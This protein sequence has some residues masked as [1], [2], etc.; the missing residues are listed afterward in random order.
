MRLLLPILL[1]LSVFG[2]PHTVLANES[3]HEA[4]VVEEKPEKKI[5]YVK[6]PG[7]DA[8]GNNYKHVA[9]DAGEPPH[10]TP[11]HPPAPPP[12]AED[13]K[14]KGKETA[15]GEHPPKASSEKKTSVK[16]NEPKKE[17]AHGGGNH[18]S[19]EQKEELQNSKLFDPNLIKL[20][21]ANRPFT[22]IVESNLYADY[23]LCRDTVNSV[24]RKTVFNEMN[25]FAD[26]MGLPRVQEAP[27]MVKVAKP[28]TNLPG[29]IFIEFYVNEQ[30]TRL[31]MVRGECGATRV[32]ML[33]VQ[34]KNS[35]K[36]QDIY[37]SYVLTDEHKYR[38]ASYCVSPS[39]QFLGQKNCYVALNPD[40]LFN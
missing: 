34:N 8:R 19:A 6:E 9:H 26:R 18:E 24:Y 32:M 13:P 16:K 37:R 14:N 29:A 23:Y 28:T 2:M 12:H 11:K 30:A 5:T 38:R 31:C 35:D 27:C 4:A 25:T 39:G 20:N 10:L 33:F 36:Y 15:R 22:K 3:A 40:W 21:A 17:S 1:W 7:I